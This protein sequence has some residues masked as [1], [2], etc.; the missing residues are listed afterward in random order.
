VEPDERVRL[1]CALRL[2]ETTLDRLVE[3]E[4]TAFAG[5]GR[6]R[7]VSRANLH[8]TLAFLGSRPARDVEAVVAELGGAAAGV[9]APVLEFERYRETRSVGMLV[10]ADEGR[11][12]GALA[13][14][15]HGRLVRL[16]VYEPERREWL[17]HVTVVRFREPPRLRLEAPDLGPVVPSDAAVYLSRLRS[18][19]AQYEVLATVPLGGR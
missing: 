11:R 4:R 9:A 10:C 14:D 12:A 1:F 16:G 17:P 2:P 8:V 5:L 15:L 13:R 3:W 19:G 18:G 7:P 6:F